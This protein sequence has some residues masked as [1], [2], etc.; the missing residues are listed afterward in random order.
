MTENKFINILLGLL[1]IGIVIALIKEIIKLNERTQ[2]KLYDDR[3][4]DELNDEKKRKKIEE[5]IEDYHKTGKWND[6][7]LT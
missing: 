6:S 3:A 4:I 2:T 5:Y 7:L 1:I